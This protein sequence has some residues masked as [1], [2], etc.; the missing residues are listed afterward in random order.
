M[1]PVAGDLAARQAA[2][3][4]ALVGGGELPDGFDHTRVAA[5]RRALLVKRAGDVTKAWPLLATSVG[6]AWPECFITWAA[7]H[8]PRGAQRDGKDFIRQCRPRLALLWSRHR[9]WFGL[10]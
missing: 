8:P 3:V 5:A 6:D 4:T 10:P 2:L 9:R 1:T 7:S